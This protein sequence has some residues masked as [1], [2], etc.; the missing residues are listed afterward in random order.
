MTIANLDKENKKIILICFVFLKFM[1]ILAK[2]KF[3]NI[4]MKIIPLNLK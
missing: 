4:Y 2:K 1:V 3:F